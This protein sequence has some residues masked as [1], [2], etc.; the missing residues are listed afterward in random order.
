MYET[1]KLGDAE[2]RRL[3]VCNPELF[4]KVSD[5]IDKAVSKKSIGDERKN[6]GNDM[7]ILDA[8]SNRA[9]RRIRE[10]KGLI[11]AET[12]ERWQA[13]RSSFAA[14]SETM[15]KRSNAGSRDTDNNYEAES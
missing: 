10:M 9:R 1:W 11:P 6:V 8:V 12:M 15:E 5:R 13:A 14:L 2:Q 4:L 7:E 3:V